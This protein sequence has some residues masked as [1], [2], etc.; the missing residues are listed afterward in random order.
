MKDVISV[1][2]PVY[3]VEA[4]LPQCLDSILSQDYDQLEVILIDDGSPDNC[5]RIC[6]AYAAKD[7]R[8][9]VIH[10]KNGGAAA[11]KNA[12]LRL[13]T[14]EYLCFADSD[15]TLEPNVYGYMLTT[16]KESGADAAEFCFRNE[17]RNRTEDMVLVTGREILE[18]KEYLRLFARE[19]HCAL[20]WNKLYK[21]ALFDGIF[22]E[23][24]HRIDDEYFTYQGMM[25]AQKV[26]RDEK[27]IYRYRMRASGAM[28]NPHAREQLMLDRVDYLEKRRKKIGERFPE[29]RKEFDHEFVNAMIYLT[30]YPENTPETIAAIKR[31]AVR[32]FVSG[33]FTIP[34][35][36]L[37]KGLLRVLCLPAGKLLKA[38]NQSPADIYLEELFA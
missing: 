4:Y 36:Y 8:I 2:V 13:A 29:L 27:I 11:A 22:F 14:G 10:Q 19:W 18:G 23:E 34:P 3:K 38:Q 15:D 33:N 31:S 25:N 1:I 37:W 5:G 20:L 21:R 35:R 24:G 26:V 32:Y 28:L 7:S 17:F 6:D 16:L 9:R 12:G 30:D